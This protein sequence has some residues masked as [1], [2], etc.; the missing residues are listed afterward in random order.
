MARAFVPN[1]RWSMDLVSDEEAAP[2]R[3][4]TPTEYGNHSNGGVGVLF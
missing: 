1:E 3:L 2:S 4:P